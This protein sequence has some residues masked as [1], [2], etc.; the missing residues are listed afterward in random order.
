MPPI[1]E[2]PHLTGALSS[3]QPAAARRPPF[4]A[5]NGQ[6]RRPPMS[7]L[8]R[9]RHRQCDRRHHRPVRRGLP[10]RERHHQGRHEPHRRGARRAALRAAW[11]RRSRLRAAAP[12]TRRQASP[13][14][15]AAPPS[16]A[17]SRT[18]SSAP[19]TRTTSAPRASPSTRRPLDGPPPTARS[20]IFVTPDGERSMNTYLGACVELGPGGRRARQGAQAPRSPISRAIS[21][22][23]RAPRRRSG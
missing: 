17:R 10:G 23:R 6:P 16:S 21:G 3:L 9:A 7:Q 11:G 4:S 19:S 14:S 1:A 15:A 5:C 12:A 18:T 8:R 2:R 13:P 22:I 20:M